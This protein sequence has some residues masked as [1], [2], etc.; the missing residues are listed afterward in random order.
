MDKV[1]SVLWWIV[2]LPAVVALLAKW[3]IGWLKKNKEKKWLIAIT[4]LGIEAYKYAEEQGTTKGLK[5]HEKLVPFMDHF[6]REFEKEFGETP[7]PEAKGQGITVMEEQVALEHI[8][9]EKEHL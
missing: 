2:T 1:I 9:R 3:I 5:G 7:T 4:R 6:I 8:N